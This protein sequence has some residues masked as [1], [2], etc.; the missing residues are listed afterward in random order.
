MVSSRAFWLGLLGSVAFLAIFAV[1]FVDFEQVWEVFKSANYVYA[2][3]SLALYVLSV[4]FRTLRWR[5][6]LRRVMDGETNRGLFPVVV[7]GY[8][9]NNLIPVRIGEV[10]RAYYLSLRERIGVSVGLGTVVLERA[11][12]VVAL[13]LLFGLAG[14]VGAIGV[15]AALTD[16]A[17]SVPGGAPILVA[18]A[19]APFLAVL[20]L[21]SI[22][23]S[24]GTA[25]MRRVLDRLFGLLSDSLRERVVDV[26]MNLLAGIAAVRTPSEML[27]VLFYSL[28]IWL[29]EISM[30]YV[31]AL[32]FDI[33]SAFE[34]EFQFIA[35][36][37]VFGSVANLAGVFPSSAGSWGPF[38]FFGA[39]A[40][41][42]LGVENG[43]AAAYALTVHVVLWAPVTIAGIVLLLADKTSL[44]KLAEGARSVAQRN[45]GQES[46]V[47]G[48][49]GQP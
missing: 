14:I 35:A 36:I 37:V 3:P 5:Y 48:T 10:M 15:G 43:L 9:A 44:A 1:L 19:I 17:E 13:L 46:G 47:S 34:S 28:L 12:D 40:L 41:V 27:R 29:A 18:V 33:R 16:V 30:Y 25:T 21:M 6:F 39:A 22:V 49:E 2:V 42:A 31:I 32:G 45:V 4:W 26:A 24:T 38:D 11:S 7:V 20:V 8:M 23:V